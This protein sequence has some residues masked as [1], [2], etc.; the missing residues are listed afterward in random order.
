M[1][2]AFAAET[3]ARVSH[4]MMAHSCVSS[5]ITLDLDLPDERRLSHTAGFNPLRLDTQCKH[6]NIGEGDEIYAR[7]MRSDL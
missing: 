1:L 3:A 4:A 5:D 2:Y 7:P 6:L